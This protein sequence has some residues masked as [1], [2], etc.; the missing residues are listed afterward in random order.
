MYYTEKGFWK[1]RKNIGVKLD[2]RGIK[3]VEVLMIGAILWGLITVIILFLMYD[4]QKVIMKQLK[5]QIDQNQE[6]I[7]R[8]SKNNEE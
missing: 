3:V 1:I 2:E 7:K 6:I 8:L 4:N 5:T